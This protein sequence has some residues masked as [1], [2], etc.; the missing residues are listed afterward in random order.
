MAKANLEV[1]AGRHANLGLTKRHYEVFVDALV[2][3]IEELGEND[4]ALLAA[5]RSALAPGIE[6]MW[7][8]REK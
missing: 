3:T 4:P 6:F 1:L 5:W 7:K 8:T 2:Q